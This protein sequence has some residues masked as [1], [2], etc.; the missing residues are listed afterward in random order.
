MSRL[1]VDTITNLSGGSVDLPGFE[2][3]GGSGGG[4]T[5]TPTNTNI[6][7]TLFSNSIFS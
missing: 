4:G 3:G 5:G 6:Y 7:G 2:G 1:K